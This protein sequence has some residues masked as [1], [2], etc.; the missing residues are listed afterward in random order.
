MRPPFSASEQTRVSR[1]FFAW[2]VL[3]LLLQGGLWADRWYV[4]YEKALS[5]VK[6]GKWGEALLHLDAALAGRD[7]PKFK[8]RTIGLEFVDYFPYY[9]QG[10]ARYRLGNLQ[11]ALLS[12]EQSRQYGESLRDAEIAR[13]LEA[14]LADCRERLAR[15]VE[16]AISKEPQKAEPQAAVIENKASSGPP[17]QESSTLEKTAQ[18]TGEPIRLP[19][20]KAQKAVEPVPRGEDV[21]DQTKAGL[22]AEGLKLLRGRELDQAELKLTTLLQLDAGHAAALDGLARSRR[23]RRV[24]HINQGISFYFSG[25]LERA[26][27]ILEESLAAED[28]D[29]RDLPRVHRFLAVIGAEKM[30]RD[31]EPTGA[32]REDVHRHLLLGAGDSAAFD[33]RYFSPR[34]LALLQQIGQEKP[35]SKSPR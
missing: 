11:G 14:M 26:R 5:A 13:D 29:P 10:L 1:L 20:P 3:L 16:P 4:D 23:A 35:S 22:L 9:H 8:A 33:A 17:M 19:E 24:I 7:K 32:L 28:T 34:L 15:K 18:A 6:G 27:I 12:L 2:A 30:L 25:D 21:L 31:G